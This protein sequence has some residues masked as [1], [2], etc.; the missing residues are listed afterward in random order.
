VE[1]DGVIHLR[2]VPYY[3]ALDAMLT[4]PLVTLSNLIALSDSSGAAFALRFRGWIDAAR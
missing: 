2:P 3:A 4:E 1:W